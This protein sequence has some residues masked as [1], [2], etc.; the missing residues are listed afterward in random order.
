M[1]YTSVFFLSQCDNHTLKK[2]TVSVCNLSDAYILTQLFKI[3]KK[4]GTGVITHVVD[5]GWDRRWGFVTK[6]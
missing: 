3:V 1:K 2:K 4:S 6:A 5:F